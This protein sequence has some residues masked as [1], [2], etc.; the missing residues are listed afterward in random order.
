MI[1][2]SRKY[3]FSASHRLHSEQLSESENQHI[4]GKC[5]YP[6]GHGHNYELEVGV[7]GPVEAKSGRAIDTTALDL[8]VST[9]ILEAFAYK[10][11][12]AEISEFRN[13]VPTT[14]NLGI[15]IHRRLNSKWRD[16]FPGQWPALDKVRIAETSRNIFEVSENGQK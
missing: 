7:K 12:N 9:E 10:N 1:H 3:R 14:E 4:Y 5:N 13:V 11:L 15:E 2:V 8:L 16:V 6:F